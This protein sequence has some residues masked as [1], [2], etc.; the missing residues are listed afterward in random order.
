MYTHSTTVPA[1][2]VPTNLTPR[3][4]RCSGRL[5]TVPQRARLA[6]R[7]ADVV[8][9]AGACELVDLLDSFSGTTTAADMVET[10]TL[11]EAT[12]DIDVIYESPRDAI[13]SWRGDGIIATLSDAR[14]GGGV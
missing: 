7:V 2:R 3:P 8:R 9:R 6:L 11:L 13:A 1:R 5:L 14:T 10:L 4:P 12:A